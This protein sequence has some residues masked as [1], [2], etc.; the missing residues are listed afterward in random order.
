M[1]KQI[2]LLE[3]RLRN[4]KGVQEFILDARCENV[5]VF[6]DNATGKTT[7][8]DSFIWLLFDKDSQNKQEFGIKTLKDGKVLHNLEHEVEGVF[9][10]DGNHLSLRKVYTEKWTQKRGS[11]T[12]EFTGHNTT[13]YIDGVPSKKK[14]YTDLVDSIVQE[15]IFKL[16][17]SPSYFNEQVKWQDRRK[18]LLE[19]CGDISEEEVIASESTLSNL[20]SILNGRT[21]ENHRKVIAA[22]RA[23][24]NKELDKIPVRI[25]EVQR[26]LP[27]LDGLN[28]ESLD[29]EINQLNADIDEK[30]T[31]I[32]SI[33]N[34][35]AISDKQKA[36]QEI[37]MEL[38]QI[39]RDHDSESKDQ[40]Y[41][42]KARI[43]EEQSNISILNSKLD[44][45][46]NQK[47][48][49]DQSIKSIEDNLVILRTE[50]H[51]VNNQ[52][53]SH[54]DQ[55]ECPTCGQSLPEEQV[56]IAREMA[57]SQF[58]LNKSNKLD[59][60]NKKGKEGAERKQEYNQNNET[61]A[62]E[63]EKLNGQIQEKQ[64][65]L[66]KLQG[67][68]KQQESLVTDILDNPSYVSK[69]QEKQSIESE[70]KNLRDMSESAVQDIQSEIIELR[71]KRDQ[72]QADHS[73]FAL[74]E[75][76][77]QR[78]SELE[79]Q[80]RDLAAEYEKLEH[81]LYLTEQFVR[82]KVKLLEE[83]IN[84]RFKYARFNLFKQNI[85]GGLE[86]ICST[87]Y[88]GVPYASGLNNA[89]KINVG[90]DIIN[91]LSEHYGFSAP[92]FIDNSEAVTK[93][94]DTT[95]QTISL[96]VSEPDKQLRVE[97]PGRYADLLIV[98][99]EVV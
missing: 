3:L 91:T 43:Q 39:K 79:E 42:M 31:Q 35:K 86:E 17:T 82:T 47:R 8:F 19:L 40:L 27:Q 30:M 88:N 51:E 32:S 50:W 36:I 77:E 73:K 61:L 10:L 63:Y 13:Y 58:N 16:L 95:A 69:I 92:I 84:N 56:A 7:L 26:S 11:A 25:S 29:Q 98:D 48:Y 90:L 75:Q 85:N 59:E 1:N 24:I 57:L 38:I 18:T 66:E 12:A 64:E 76:S 9:L 23:E 52:E 62:K 68:L 72:L 5:K 65:S 4:F 60:I 80:Q 49:N 2:K 53:F 94:I 67:Q 14:E 97:Y 44:N 21:I 70:I 28:K 46:K 54:N 6:G 99:N 71:S 87:T 93:L 20:P 55:C 15:D 45:V 33:R 83:K 89:A 81:Q 41:Q 78:I 74:A 34:G 22:R 96:V 37:E